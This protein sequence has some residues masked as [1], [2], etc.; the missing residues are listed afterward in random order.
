V[1][2]K[3]SFKYKSRNLCQALPLLPQARGICKI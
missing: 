2:M 1:M 3:P